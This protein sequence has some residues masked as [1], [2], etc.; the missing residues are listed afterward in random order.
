[1]YKRQELNRENRIK[2]K[3]EINE[4]Y[5]PTQIRHVLEK[6]PG[7]DKNTHTITG[8][9][10]ESEY[11]GICYYPAV[12]NAGPKLVFMFP[13]N[14][15]IGNTTGNMSEN[16]QKTNNIISNTTSSRV[17]N[18]PVE[19]REDQFK[20]KK[21]TKVTYMSKDNNPVHAILRMEATKTVDNY[22]L[23]AVDKIMTEN[24][25]SRYRKVYVDIAYVSNMKDS[26]WCR[27]IINNS[28]TSSVFV[29]CK[30]NDSKKKWEPIEQMG[31]EIKLPSLMSDIRDS[32]IEIEESD[33][34]SE[35][36]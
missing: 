30:W 34:D 35:F 12:T 10:R 28:P 26:L 25:N 4:L 33:S 2:L 36:E 5:E 29:K 7:Y 23:Y 31:D 24:G 16:I 14:N 9:I 15:I 22:K 21:I 18:E 11:K 27:D 32:L 3:L 1:M 19:K 6:I 17:I 20:N 8:N 13:D